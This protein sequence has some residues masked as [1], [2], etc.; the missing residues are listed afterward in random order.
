MKWGLYLGVVQR[1]F[2]FKKRFRLRHFLC[3]CGIDILQIIARVLAHELKIGEDFALSV[4][5]SK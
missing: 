5:S 2:L 3:R 4:F 1:I